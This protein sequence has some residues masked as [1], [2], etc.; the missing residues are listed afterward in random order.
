MNVYNVT[1][2][3][4][5]RYTRDGG[6][7]RKRARTDYVVV[8]HA[9][10]VYR[11]N[12]GV[13]D[14]F[15]IAKYH[16]DLPPNGNGWPGI[17]YH[18]VLAE[19]WNGGP[20]ARYIVSTPEL[21]RAH[22]W[23]QNHIAYG[24]CCAHNFSQIPDK[25]WI[26]AIGAAVLQAKLMYP[27]ATIVGHKDISLPGHST[28]C[29][30]PVWDQWKPYIVDSY[31]VAARR[32]DEL[33]QKVENVRVLGVAPSITF[34]KWA[35]VLKRHGAQLS[36]AEMQ[37]CYDLCSYLEVDPAFM[38]ALWIRESGSPL[39]GSELQQ[40]SRCPIN[41]K[42][43]SAEWRPT[44]EYRGAKWLSFESFQL[45]MMAS[46]LH[47]KNV[48]GWSG[49]V[50]VRDILASHAPVSENDT[51]GVTRALLVDLNNIRTGG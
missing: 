8:H 15:A 49:R 6:Y 43:A 20:I 42:A 18:E 46:I 28:G 30:S 16:W 29:P 27:A 7:T 40:K 13:D 48:H 39:G 36:T 10:A 4:A 22:V 17:G 44:V 31:R 37:R 26:D 11:T 12:Q 14:V 2:E 1:D 25:K 32:H 45:G 5:R 23:G 47:I 19:E 34:T 9:A 41:I 35:D 50:G 3:V 38:I 33:K 24:I 21:E 51:S